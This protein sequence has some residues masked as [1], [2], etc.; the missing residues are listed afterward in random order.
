MGK[1]EFFSK[2]NIKDYN[3]ELEKVLEKKSFSESAK[4]VLLNILYKIETAYED[5]TKV[6]AEIRTKRE[7]LEEVINTIEHNCDEIELVKPNL[8][9]KTKLGDK[10]FIVE[11]SNKKIISYPNE[12]TVYYGI[13]HL[14]NNTIV[15]NSKYDILK[16]PMEK[17]LNHG[18]IMEQEEIIRD[19]DGWTWNIASEEIEDYIC[20]IVYQNIKML[21]GKKFLLDYINKIS[22][23]DFIDRFEKKI[24]SICN[25]EL[26]NQ[27][28]T[29]IYQIAIIEYIKNNETKKNE[30]YKK[31]KCLQENLSKM[32]NKKAYLQDLANKKKRIGKEIKEIDEIVNN[33]KVLREKFIE[34]N[35]KLSEK[36]KIFSLS[37]YSEILQNK[38]KE[39]L[40]QLKHY[41][42]L[43]K[44]I[45]YVKTKSEL[46]KKLDI[47]SE[48]KF[49]GNLKG[50][51]TK[52]LIELQQVFLK[53]TDEKIKKIELKKDILNYIYLF[54]YYKL[55][56]I[57][58]QEQ[59]K[60]IEELKEALIDTEKYLITRGCNLKAINI[61]CHN[62]EKNYEIISKI[63]SSNIIDLEEVYIEFKKE[64]KKIILD[65][66]DDNIIDNSIEYEGKE[67]LNV[68]FNKKVKLFI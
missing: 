2:L 22:I 42:L 46:K 21:V 33:N 4:N 49:D 47:L 6:K 45:N 14:N 54:R 68:K 52:L 39:L 12:K 64:D 59:V 20:N 66:Y 50:Q 35:K 65:V 55:L 3:N 62:I 43:M 51:S 26:A 10:R 23:T 25:E 56:K 18:Y 32:E 48:I 13:C 9:K 17:L 53:F 58:R 44:P 19:F 11:K 40:K 16:A 30:L 36:E 7:I 27:L 41:G 1:E 61:L 57:N 8:E 37:E 31:E 5:Y 15:I 60:D 28:I 67:E 29:K 63:L 38:R 34:E 24:I